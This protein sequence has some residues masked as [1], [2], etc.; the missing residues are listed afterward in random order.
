MKSYE[1]VSTI[2]GELAEMVKPGIECLDMEAWAELRVKEL[3]GKS[4][5]KGYHPIWAQTPYPNVL[6]INVN[7]IVAHG[8]PF[9]Y[10]LVEGDIVAFDLGVLDSDGDC[11]D[12]AITV[13]VG[14]VSN[15]YDR[16]VRYAKAACYE[17]IKKIRAGVNTIEITRA[18]EQYCLARNLKVSRSFTGHRIGKEMH[19]EPHIHNTVEEKATYI[20]LEKGWIVCIEPMVTTGRDNVGMKMPNGWTVVTADRKPSAMFEHMVEVTDDGYKILTTHFQP[21]AI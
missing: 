16:L 17:G 13:R 14:E 18:I 8:I 19:M 21:D 7:N 11:G 9:Q 5:N 10:K 3:G 1:I 2:L 20:P 15:E 12:A 6:C 4:Y